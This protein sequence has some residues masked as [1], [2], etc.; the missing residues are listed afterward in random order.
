MFGIS[1][2][3]AN[4]SLQRT[5][6]H[7]PAQAVSLTCLPRQSCSASLYAKVVPGAWPSGVPNWH[8]STCVANGDAI[9]T[10]YEQYV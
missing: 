10:C 1:V 9:L 3:G 4:D 2:C 7:T 8:G 5:Q 6:M